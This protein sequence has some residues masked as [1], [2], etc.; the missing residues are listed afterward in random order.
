MPTLPTRS[1]QTIVAN[2]VAGI[3]GRAS[4][5]I[6]FGD[7]SPLR[8]IVEGF[9]G[10]FLWFQTLALQI[11]SASRL[12]TSQGVDV[13]T[14]TADFM[15]TIGVSNGVPSPRLGA[16]AASGLLQFGRYTAGSSTCFVPVG[17]TAQ[18]QDGTQ[19]AV[20]TADPTF[21]TFSATLNGYTMAAGLSTLTVPASMQ[22]AGS[23]GNVQAGSISLLTSP[24]TGID[25]VVNLA[26][27]TNGAD[28]ESDSALKARFALYIAGLSRGDYYGTAAAID[29]TNVTVQW[30]IVEDYS[31]A[32]GWQPG[33]Y[34][35]VADDGSGAPPPSFM[36]AITNAVWAVRPLSIQCAVFPPKIKFVD[37]QIEVA[38]ATGYDHN[39]V[40]GL[41]A[42]AISNGINS[43]GLG[44][45]LDFNRISAWAYSV[46][47]VTKVSAVLLNGIAG[48]AADVSASL[49]TQDGLSSMPIFTIKTASVQVS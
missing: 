39:T 34:F 48:D 24:L 43:L 31:Y 17:A 32:G 21:P 18:T 11:L 25:T 20:V 10:V 42:N 45:D 4:A 26:A 35:V 13:D 12:S 6:D 3:Q 29:G 41:V 38:T 5:L 47:G 27:F 14:F 2:A 46:A 16:Q 49:P 37:V 28:Q 7:G 44:I 23:A 30:Q 19:T 15:P 8:A 33:F 22:T 1:F 40:V 9:A 36:Q